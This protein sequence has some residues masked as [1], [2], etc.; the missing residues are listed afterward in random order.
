VWTLDGAQATL[1]MGKLERAGLMAAAL[2]LLA[3][4][5]NLT[6]LFVALGMGWKMFTKDLPPKDDWGT[7]VYFAAVL[8]G[9]GYLL[10]VVPGPQ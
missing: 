10:H 3:Y 8:A 2:A 1:A 5:G 6:F 9:L 4:T 7:W